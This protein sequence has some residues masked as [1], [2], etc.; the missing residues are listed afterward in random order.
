MRS[1][2]KIGTSIAASILRSAVLVFVV[3][4]VC[5]VVV[6]SLFMN[7]LMDDI[8]L[9]VLR[10]M[11][12]T[13]AQSVEANLHTLAN[14]FL[15]IRDNNAFRNPGSDLKYKQA[16]LDRAES[17]IEFVW[18]GLYNFN[19]TLLTGSENCP[20]SLAGRQ[21]LPLMHQTQNLVIEDVAIGNS[22]LE[23]VMGV[24]EVADGRIAQGNY[25]VGSYQY[26]ILSD[27]LN[28]INIGSRGTAFII[29]EDGQFI[30]HKNLGK[31][32]SREPIAQSFGA[33]PEAQQAIRLMKQGQVD[34][35][36]LKSADEPMFVS[37][38]PIRGTR[39]SL[40]IQA[41]RS[42]F[43]A[44][45]RTAYLTAITITLIFLVC[46]VVIFRAMIKRVLTTPLNVITQYANKLAQGQF[47]KRLPKNL[48]ERNDEI[49]RL[50]TAFST[51]SDSVREVIDDISRL[52]V[53]S[54]MGNLGLRTNPDAHHGDYYRIISAINAT[55]DS[56]CSYLDAMP[57]A[58]ALFNEKRQAIYL[59]HAMGAIISLH[60]LKANDGRILPS[61]I[62]PDGNG[63][64]PK[65]VVD[66]F[67]PAYKET[68]SF[69]TDVLLVGADN[70]NYSYS[71][72]IKRVNVDF[73][74]KTAELQSG[75]CL[76]LVLSDVTMLSN[77]LVAAEAASK[78]KSEFL[79]N[80]SHEIRTPM[81]AV[82]GL[83]H[84]L[85]QTELDDQ[86]QE[87]AK[88]AHRSSKVLLGVINDILDFSK[89][90]AGKMTV[91]YI[92][93]V[94]QEALDDIKIFFRETCNKSS[95]DLFFDIQPD[96]PNSLIGDP[97]RLRQVFINIVG[98]AFKFTKAGSITVSARLR[99]SDENSA[100]ILFSVLDTGIG[101]S[102]DQAAKLFKG[103]TQA[104]TSIT[105]QY[106]GTGLGL[107][108]TK[109]LV[110]LMGGEISLETELNKG[111]ILYFTCRF[112]LSKRLTEIKQQQAENK[113]AAPTIADFKKEDDTAN[114]L[115]LL[116][117]RVL[118]V[119][120]NEV[121]V[122]VARSLMKKMGLA[123]TVAEN[124]KIALE[125]LDE[126]YNSGFNPPFDVVFMDLQ[127]P[128]MGG[129]E[130]TKHIRADGR[131]DN[132]I[133]VAMTAH[134]FTEAK[135]RCLADGMNGHLAKPIDVKQFSLTLRHFIL[136]DPLDGQA[137]SG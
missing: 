67:D 38:A 10:P 50:T 73:H 115:S 79:A 118:L 32:F 61:L 70:S 107:A 99:F 98:N 104:D 15:L 65:A 27:V 127:M 41:P 123:V 116:G 14:N 51:M 81:N 90:E 76:I 5:L 8:M 34:S 63:E 3:F 39:W 96:L 86:Q 112:G 59:N 133:I 71:L 52:A 134:A 21:L 55:L 58:L 114:D 44:P 64:L 35:A 12:K 48:S 23:I 97:L 62:N 84:L 131:F 132:L 103:F 56:I 33:G 85:L 19:G 22:G 93:F 105:R 89:V 75:I 74:G 49:G 91:E 6:M 117:R 25:L 43:M 137:E 82:L 60:G 2:M 121:N 119:E 95:I 78:A 72:K 87:Y 57:G 30:A 36:E 92:P 120:D 7:T 28:N 94:L 18:L 88:N 110:Q 129:Y 69:Q 135:E 136:G 80:M 111:T 126:A 4:S 77:A 42:D 54:G 106:G 102:Q 11:A 45:V 46:F 31:V 68:D 1:P 100:V 20:R 26:D 108:I 40:G 53:A 66:L 125:C 109:S 122:L 9:H 83:T 101:M 113:P 17:G 16:V 124:G 128:V 37:Y 130:A 47:A 13:A 24:P 29:N